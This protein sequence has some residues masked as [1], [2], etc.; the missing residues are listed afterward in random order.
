MKALLSAAVELCLL[1]LGP[2]H[3]P[4]SP[5]LLG[6]LLLLNLIVGSAG[7]MLRG[8]EFS[9]A[10]LESLFELVVMLLVLH[11]ALKL[12]RKL[13]RFYQTGI[14]LLLSGILLNLLALPLVSWNQSSATVESVLLQWLLIFWIIL[15]VGH[16]IRHAFNV[17]LNVGIAIS[18]FYTLASW[19]LA[20]MLFPVVA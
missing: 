2:Q 20:A 11:L 9:K 4:A 12:T 7:V 18:L 5:A 14:A 1:R 19:S 10:M 3:M 17:D 15:V 6:L 13:S 16:I 8:I